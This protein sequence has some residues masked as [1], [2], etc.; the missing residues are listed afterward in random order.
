MVTVKEK[1]WQAREKALRRVLKGGLRLDEPMSRHTTIAVGGNARFMAV[2]RSAQQVVDLVRYA[3][4][5][6]LDYFVVGKGSNL[7]V[8]DG[9]YKG[10]IVKMDAYLT[11]VRVNQASV[12][13]EAGASFAR[14]CRT[15]TKGG[16]AGMEFGVGIPG[17]AGGAVV[18]NAG[19]YGSDVSGVLRRVRLIDGQGVERVFK[20]AELEFEYRKTH[21]PP[22]SVVLSATF[23]CPPGEINRE[24]YNRAL[25]RKETQPISQ[26]TFGSTFVNP[27]GGHAAKMIEE[28]GLKGT[29]CGG[30]VV[31]EKHANFI[32]NVEGTASASDVEGLIEIVRREV[33][34]KFRVTL[35]TEVVIIGNQ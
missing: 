18:M 4:S 31:S 14:L 22:R 26:R 33:K 2:P 7:I 23:A 20:A 9:G 12:F 5:E 16:R 1:S 15:V 34:S 13:A 28:C 6:G 32:V 21:L 25:S 24:T 19:A 8:R 3:V 11:R 30:A 27:P 10:I 35:K 29:R 17:T